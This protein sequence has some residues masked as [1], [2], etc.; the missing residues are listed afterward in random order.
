MIYDKDLPLLPL[1]QGVLR[2]VQHQRNSRRKPPGALSKAHY[3]DLRVTRSWDE[4]KVNLVSSL[5]QITRGKYIKRSCKEGHV[6]PKSDAEIE[7]GVGE[8]QIYDTDTE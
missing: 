2:E 1:P 8:S 4:K 5:G 6:D 3:R 7:R